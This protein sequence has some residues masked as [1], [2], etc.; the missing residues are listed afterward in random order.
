MALWVASFLR[1]FAST[2]FIDTSATTCFSTKWY[3]KTRKIS[4]SIWSK[5][6]SQFFINLLMYAGDLLL[7]K[8]NILAEHC[9]VSLKTIIINV[10]SFLHKMFDT[11]TGMHLAADPS[12]KTNF[13]SSVLSG[14]H[15]LGLLV[16]YILKEIVIYTRKN[17]PI[18]SFLGENYFFY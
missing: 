8:R 10:I 6:L 11:S 9:K 1:E 15:S 14:I 12:K 3:S 5:F 7:I 18:L 16:Q 13:Y 2:W 17:N 4:C